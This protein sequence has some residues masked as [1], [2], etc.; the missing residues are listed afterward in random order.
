MEKRTQDLIGKIYSVLIP[1]ESKKGWDQGSHYP[2]K[3]YDVGGDRLYMICMGVSKPGVPS[4]LFESGVGSSSTGWIPIQR[5]LSKRTQVCAYDRVGY[6]WSEEW[7]A[8]RT[9]QSLQGVLPRSIDYHVET[10][11]RLLIQAKIS[12]P[13]ILV[14]HSYGGLISLAFEA[15]YSN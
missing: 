14:G 3:L 7:S 15:K 11:E 8:L 1:S 12:G 13:I 6:G 9:I 10:L 5:E 2:G 4:I